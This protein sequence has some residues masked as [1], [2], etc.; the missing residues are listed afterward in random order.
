MHLSVFIGSVPTD[1]ENGADVR[2]VLFYELMKPGVKVGYLLIC[3]ALVE[4]KPAAR[5]L[6][7]DAQHQPSERAQVLGNPDDMLV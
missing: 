5:R 4:S 6:M 1:A 3:I 7:I 2:S